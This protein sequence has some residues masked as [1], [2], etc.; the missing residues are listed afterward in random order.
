VHSFGHWGLN[1]LFIGWV[2][3]SEA[4]GLALVVLC[5]RGCDVMGGPLLAFAQ[6]AGLPG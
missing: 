5:D 1:D 6:E 4:H 2:N 3:V